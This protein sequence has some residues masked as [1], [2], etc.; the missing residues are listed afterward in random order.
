MIYAT[1]IF[2][3]ETTIITQRG[4]RTEQVEDEARFIVDVFLRKALT[5][6]LHCGFIMRYALWVF[7][8]E[9]TTPA[10]QRWLAKDWSP[11]TAVLRTLQHS[12]TPLYNFNGHEKKKHTPAT[13]HSRD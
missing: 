6:S 11:V 5:V 9:T 1:I 4:K 8:T 7:E 10:I 13:S 12:Y 2:A 3:K